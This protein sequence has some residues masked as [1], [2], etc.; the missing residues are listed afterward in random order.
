M[1]NLGNTDGGELLFYRIKSLLRHSM[2]YG[3][4]EFLGKAGSFLLVPLY[5]KTLPSSDYGIIE[6]FA[7]TASALL[8]FTVMGFNSALTRYYIVEQTAT[9]RSSFFQT[10]ILC[11]SATGGFLTIV[12][13]AFAPAVSEVLFGTNAYAS[14]CRVLVV[15]VFLDSLGAMFLA[16]FRAQSKPLKYS[17][18]NLGKL[19]ITL[20]LNVYFVGILDLG[21]S[22]VLLGNLIGSSAGF[23]AGLIF[24][25]GEQGGVLS[26]THAKSLARFGFP[27]LFSGLGLFLMNSSDRY[28]LKA[29][30]TLA[31]LG[32][33][34]VGYK[35][36]MVMS[37]AVSA[38]TVAWP[39]IMFK[40]SADPHAK[41]TFSTILTYYVFVTGMLF[42]SVSSFRV[43]IVTLI[44]TP[45]Y[46]GASQVVPFIL[47]SYLLQGVY[48]ILS[49]GVTITDHTKMVPIVVGV[50][51]LINTAANLI[52]IPPYGIM[53]AAVATI[54]SYSV[55]P[56][57]MFLASQRYYHI[58]FERQ[59]L[60]KLSLVLGSLAA[61]NGVLPQGKGVFLVLRFFA[62]LLFPVLLYLWKFF[63]PEEIHRFRAWI[64]RISSPH[65]LP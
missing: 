22:G 16:L 54:I 31:D 2:V 14:F 48:Y 35:I 5:A 51:A 32:V 50:G 27:L 61:F 63:S 17:S 8:I 46:I 40:I 7:V 56:V 24:A 10:S 37:L 47:M 41:R 28:F 64:S 57:G 20:L 49:A 1:N 21:V 30:A 9:G 4:F 6:L 45:E 12:L 43:E 3:T 15:T 23:L 38:F 18:I 26:F 11:V 39:P 42:L 55:L 33:Y 25:S 19:I 13:L 34:A 58:P 36:G 52:L 60:L 29:F 65:S 53:G 44:G 62:V 59:R